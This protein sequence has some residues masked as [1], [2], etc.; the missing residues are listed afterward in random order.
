MNSANSHTIGP[1]LLRQPDWPRGICIACQ[2]PQPTQREYLFC[3]PNGTV[4]AIYNHD[5]L[6]QAL[7]AHLSCLE[8]FTPGNYVYLNT[9]LDLALRRIA[10][11]FPALTLWRVEAR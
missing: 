4:N 3:T 11:H 7:T 6:P 9:R 5:K 2:V 8:W 1:Y 10:P